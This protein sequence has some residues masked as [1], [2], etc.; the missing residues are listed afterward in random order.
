MIVAISILLSMI[1]CKYEKSKIDYCDKMI[2]LGSKVTAL[3]NT[4][5]PETE[6]IF[7]L[8][9]KS[10]RLKDIDLKDI[11]SS[12]PLKSEENEKIS[13]YIDSIGKYDAQT[14][15]NKANEFCEA[16]RLL[17]KDYQQYYSSHS[18]IIYALGFSVGC[19][20]AILLI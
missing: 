19:A 13:E 17:K 3:L 14:Q 18:K 2:F 16:F 4:T 5:Q 1:V 11:P 10:E 7:A 12:S 15:I 20:I 9:N 8:L 6:K